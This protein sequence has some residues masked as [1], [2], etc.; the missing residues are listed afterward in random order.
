VQVRACECVRARA[1]LVCCVACYVAM[2]E[3]HWSWTAPWAAM[4]LDRCAG[5]T[6][7]LTCGLGFY[8]T[9]AACECET[10][11]Q[12]WIKRIMC[13][14]E[15]LCIFG[16]VEGMGGIAAP[17][18]NHDQDCKIPDHCHIGICG[19]SCKDLSMLKKLAAHLRAHALRYGTG[20]SATTLRGLANFLLNHPVLVYVG[21][22]LDE[23]ANLDSDNAA[24][25]HEIFSLCGYAIGI[26]IAV[27]K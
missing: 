6:I 26:R 18:S 2:V 23:L 8:V 19:W 20:T 9:K 14:D 17:C 12:H 7:C 22:N 11:K 16:R 10:L 27:Y 25:V 21:E 4:D 1:H 13:D 15:D 24:F 5:D 3:G